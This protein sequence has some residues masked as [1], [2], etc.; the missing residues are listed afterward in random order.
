M[1]RL[2]SLIEAAKA[3]CVENV[4]GWVPG[5]LNGW[6]EDVLE[7]CALLEKAEEVLKYV[8]RVEGDAL[9]TRTFNRIKEALSAIKQWKEQT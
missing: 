9:E 3:D 6:G 2:N 4:N 8:L 1:N 5:N 7:L